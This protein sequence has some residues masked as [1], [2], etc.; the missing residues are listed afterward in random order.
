MSAAARSQPTRAAPAPWQP[1][2]PPPMVEPLQQLRAQHL[3]MV[4]LHNTPRGNAVH[5]D[6]INNIDIQ[7]R[8]LELLADSISRL[9]GQPATLRREIEQA[10][11]HAAAAAQALHTAYL[12]KFTGKDPANG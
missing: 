11:R 1:R 10:L 3:A 2:L 7:R 5:I 8:E 12:A 6:V 4:A 9:H